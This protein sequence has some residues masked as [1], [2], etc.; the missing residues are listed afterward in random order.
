[1]SDQAQEKEKSGISIRRGSSLETKMEP[2]QKNNVRPRASTTTAVYD[3]SL[4]NSPRPITNQIG[5]L[6]S[7]H[8]PKKTVAQGI[9]TKKSPTSS[10][11]STKESLRASGERQSLDAKAKLSLSPTMRKIPKISQVSA[12]VSSFRKPGELPTR[13]PKPAIKATSGRNTPGV[14]LKPPER[15]PSTFHLK[16]SMVKEGL[17]EAVSEYL[18]DEIFDMDQHAA[19][20]QAPPKPK[21]S[22]GFTETTQ[23]HTI[24]EE[25][26]H[27][28]MD[29]QGNAELATYIRKEQDVKIS[30][31]AEMLMEVQESPDMSHLDEDEILGLPEKENASLPEL[32]NILLAEKKHRRRAQMHLERNKV[33]ALKM[34]TQINEILQTIIYYKRVGEQEKTVLEDKLDELM[35]RLEEAQRD[36]EELEVKF[37][38]LRRQ[39]NFYKQE[40]SSIQDRMD[41]KAT[42]PSVPRQTPS[43]QTHQLHNNLKRLG[44]INEELSAQLEGLM[45]SL[46]E[47]QEDTKVD[48]EHLA[49]LKAEN[50]IRAEEL[51]IAKALNATQEV[52]EPVSAEVLPSPPTEY[53]LIKVCSPG[54]SG[55]IKKMVLLGDHLWIGCSDGVIRI[56]DT[57]TVQM[58]EDRQA[59]V[60]AILDMKAVANRV[61]SLSKDRICIWSPKKSTP[62]KRMML[63]EEILSLLEVDGTVWGGGLSTVKIWDSKTVK[64]RRELQSLSPVSTMLNKGECIWMGTRS[65]I[66][67]WGSKTLQPYKTLMGHSNTI[68]HMVAVGTSQVWS[69]SQDKTVRCWNTEVMT[70]THVIETKTKV[71]SLLALS[72][73]PHVWGGSYGNSIAVWDSETYEK[74]GDLES[75]PVGAMVAQHLDMRGELRLWVGSQ[76]TTVTLWRKDLQE[77]RSRR[78]S[79]LTIEPIAVTK[80]KTGSTL[81]LKKQLQLMDANQRTNLD[82]M[83]TALQG[84]ARV[85]LGRRTLHKLKTENIY[86]R[87]VVMELFKTE[88]VYLNR[89]DILLKHFIA[90][91]REALDRGKPILKQRSV[92]DLCSSGLP[93]IYTYNQGLYKDLAE[94]VKTWNPRQLVGDLFLKFGEGLSDVYAHY[95]CKDFPRAQ[96]V[97]DAKKFSKRFAEFISECKQNS[98]TGAHDMPA[99]LVLPV[100]RIPRYSLLLSDLVK[101]TW[102]GHQDYHNLTAALEKM[103]A[104][105]VSINEIKRDSE[106]ISKQLQVQSIFDGKILGIEDPDTEFIR[107]DSFLL[108]DSKLLN[109]TLM[110]AKRQFFLFNNKLVRVKGESDK[111]SKGNFKVEDIY[112]LKN[113]AAGEGPSD[114]DFPPCSLQISNKYDRVILVLVTPSLEVMQS[115]LSD[116]TK[117]RSHLLEEAKLKTAEA[118]KKS[119]DK[120]QKVKDLFSAQYETS[121]SPRMISSYYRRERGQFMT[122]HR[123]SMRRDSESSDDGGS[124]TSED[125]GFRSGRRGFKSES[126]TVSEA[127]DSDSES[128][129]EFSSGSRGSLDEGLPPVPSLT[130]P[131]PKKKW[132]N[133][134]AKLRIKER[135]RSV[136]DVFP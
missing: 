35:F 45:A 7:S 22:V 104:V 74:L 105:A 117:C 56:W 40:K 62:V 93:V 50:Q 29:D 59:H 65:H 101:H 15:V 124:T 132:F 48:M 123:A 5:T 96:A 25:A 63:D 131:P 68:T 19:P 41:T 67:V 80:R 110:T 8:S 32:Q 82:K 79:V 90:P 23:V 98:V 122:K 125:R 127:S 86:R 14:F 81:L 49:V 85:W 43:T 94:R 42:S 77:G 91:L 113:I 126:D 108:F 10:T 61:W 136:S 83:V 52:V 76:D 70:C 34:R 95:I 99:L 26:S 119:A 78:K 115:W 121:V 89:L 73:T 88:E 47:K 33:S 24:P 103:Q 57:Q 116:F 4:T 2:S 51:N 100:Q 37:V 46:R 112:D 6:S 27:L 17:K 106:K 64:L 18:E 12:K 109:G 13:N 120:A 111:L 66:Y 92:E 16:E 44:T 133:S 130:P 129:A 3:S 60:D 28:D 69:C 84:H 135:S 71:T 9:P 58:L 30:K 1:M 54:H 118:L 97:Y 20:V 114:S 39:Q 31:W 102:T 128:E 38:L 11:P 53:T 21:K 134:L 55:A 87:N 75:A 107:E 36:K 72:P